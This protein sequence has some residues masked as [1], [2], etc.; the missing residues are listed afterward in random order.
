MSGPWHWAEFTTWAD[1]RRLEPLPATLAGTRI[2]APLLV[3]FA[4]AL[5]RSEIVAL[6]AE[7]L[8]EVDEGLVLTRGQVQ[9][10][11]GR[12]RA[13]HRDPLRVPTC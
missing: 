4:G 7:N 8:Q 10:R 12:Q 13:A 11:P 9:D 1:H 3:G 2:E 5:R 6:A